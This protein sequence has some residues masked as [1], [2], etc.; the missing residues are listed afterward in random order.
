[1][2]AL[3]ETFKE[4]AADSELESKVVFYPRPKQI[5]EFDLQRDNQTCQGSNYGKA[6]RVH[7]GEKKRGEM[8]EALDRRI[9]FHIIS[10]FP[11]TFFMTFSMTSR[12]T[13]PGTVRA[14]EFRAVKESGVAGESWGWRRGEV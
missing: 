11:L 6:A 13:S 9:S 5:V 2:S 7:G 1:V 10:S 12:V 3:A 4:F 8:I 14:E